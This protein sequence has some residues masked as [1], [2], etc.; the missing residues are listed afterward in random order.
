VRL[1][2]PGRDEI[3]SRLVVL[4]GSKMVCANPCHAVDL[5]YLLIINLDR[6]VP[7]L[8]P[9]HANLGRRERDSVRV[10]LVVV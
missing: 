6:N 3:L 9:F 10:Y 5:E 7:L 2:R 8:E 4:A 1:D